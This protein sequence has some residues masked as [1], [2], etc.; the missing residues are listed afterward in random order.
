MGLPA[1]TLPPRIAKQAP[2]P[3]EKRVRCP[4][5]L[6]WVRGFHCAVEGCLNLPVEAAHVRRGTD[7]GMG[8]KPSD[9]WAIP[10]CQTHH[11]QQHFLGEES[12]ETTY[13]LNMRALAREFSARSPHRM[14]WKG[15]GP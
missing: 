15:R 6:K 10:L 14:K 7:G 4:S 3:R 1:V 9:F 11:R 2:A 13:A 12:F 5:H 8:M